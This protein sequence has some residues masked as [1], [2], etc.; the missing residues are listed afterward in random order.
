M[1]GVSWIAAPYLDRTQTNYA[2]SPSSCM[3]SLGLDAPLLMSH[4]IH[5]SFGAQPRRM[6]TGIHKATAMVVLPLAGA[7]AMIHFATA[8]KVWH[9]LSY[10]HHQ[11]SKGPVATLIPSIYKQFSAKSSIS[12]MDKLKNASHRKVPIRGYPLFEFVSTVR[13]C[14]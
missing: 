12:F 10:H 14:S 11:I 13:S 9:F 4:L 5:P 6:E 2:N 1:S 7:I 3:A 8:L